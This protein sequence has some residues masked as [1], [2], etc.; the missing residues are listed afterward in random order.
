MDTKVLLAFPILF[1]IFSIHPDT[2]DPNNPNDILQS[3]RQTRLTPSTQWHSHN[4]DTTWK[5]SNLT[6]C[7]SLMAMYMLLSQYPSFNS[8]HINKIEEV[9]VNSWP[10]K[11]FIKNSYYTFLY[12]IRVE[13]LL[14]S[15]LD[16]V[17]YF[18]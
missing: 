7:Y 13:V 11:L 6:N 16:S 9:L 17:V 4:H 10:T 18:I 2:M 1:H 3:R 8:Y 14:S 5:A 15:N 12:G